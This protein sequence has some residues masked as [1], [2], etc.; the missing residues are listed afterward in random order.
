[1]DLGQFGI[2]RE[3]SEVSYLNMR[4]LVDT[5]FTGFQKQVHLSDIVYGQITLP[6]YCWPVIDSPAMQRLKGI[7]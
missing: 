2:A 7:H 5:K 4:E 3:T 1:M 6:A